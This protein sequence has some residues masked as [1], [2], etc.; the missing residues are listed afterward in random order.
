[1][2]ELGLFQ[3]IIGGIVALGLT[4]FAYLNGR[5]TNIHTKH[6]EFRTHVAEKYSTKDDTST[7]ETKLSHTLDRVHGRMDNIDKNI[8]ELPKQIMEYI[9]DK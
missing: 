3:W 7:V 4:L 2:V 9:K 8:R 5:V 6:Q 1:M